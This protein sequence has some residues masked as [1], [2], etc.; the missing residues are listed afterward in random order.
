MNIEKTIQDNHEAKLVVEFDR[1]KFEGYKRRAARKISERG[2]IPG[3]RPGKAPYEIVVRNYGEEAIVEQAVDFLIDEEYSNILKEAGV[4]PGAAGTLESIDSLQPP[5]FTF[6]VPL[7]PEVDLGDYLSIRLPYEWSAPDEK[8]VD[9]ALEDLRQRYATTET[10]DRP[11]EVGDYVLVEVKSETEG[12]NRTGFAVWVRQEGSDAEW[13]YNGFSGEL[14]GLKAGESKKIQHKLPTDWEAAELQGR[15]VE[16]EVTVKTVRG[17][18]LPDLDDDFAKRTGM[19]ETLDALREAM[20]ED[21]QERSKAEYDDKYFEELIEK[22]K[23]GATI[24][25]H[26]SLLKDESEHVLEKFANRLSLEGMDLE[27]YVRLRNTTREKLIEEEIT[28]IMQPRLERFLLLDEVIRRERI[29]VENDAFDLEFSDMLNSLTMQSLVF[30]KMRGSKQDQQ[31][32]IEALAIKSVYNA[33]RR[34]AFAILK[35]IA[36]GEYKPPEERVEA[37]T[38]PE[39][40]GGSESIVN[41]EKAEQS[42]ADSGGA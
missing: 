7:A 10:V 5:K 21:V 4:E 24:K 22:V 1:D 8:E 3:F 12:L 15:E 6:T 38:P 33:M 19:G 36:V 29:G 30:S 34:T 2:K 40:S 37:E 23:A 31:L 11:V 20:T 32:M 9:A 42:E 35:S 13:P 27:T 41:E 28:P 39:N 14:I 25:Y 18:I 26:P 17:V 16:L